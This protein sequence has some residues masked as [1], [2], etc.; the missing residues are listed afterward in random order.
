[1]SL[2]VGYKYGEPIALRA[3]TNSLNSFAA[4]Y[5]AAQKRADSKFAGKE[6][7][8]YVSRIREGSII[9]ELTPYVL[10]GKTL[11][12]NS[13][14]VLDFCGH[15]KAGLDFLQGLKETWDE[16]NKKSAE[17]L[18]KIVAPAAHDPAATVTFQA[19]VTVGSGATFNLTINYTGAEKIQKR[20]KTYIQELEAPAE[21]IV[22][23]TELSWYQARNDV[24]SK[25]GDR[26]IIEALS[27]KPVKVMFAT[28]AIKNQILAEDHNLF[29]RAYVVDV[30]AEFRGKS[31][32]LYR[33]IKI[34][35][36]A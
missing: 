3:L 32:K 10:A 20:A 14:T 9:A 5:N 27:E 21:N 31:P 12:E 30:V 19:P 26:A 2:E 35:S 16:G 13:N 25:S 33:I 17:N 22:Y 15:L 7:Q 1:M 18:A 8:L 23:E 24:L 29:K 6:A 11:M 36:A 34:H 28:D 4:E